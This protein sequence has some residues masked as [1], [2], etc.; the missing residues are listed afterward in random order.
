MLEKKDDLV[1][2]DFNML[3]TEKIYYIN[4]S[5]W[6]PSGFQLKKKHRVLF[7]CHKVQV[8]LLF[9]VFFEFH[10][11]KHVYVAVLYENRTMNIQLEDRKIMRVVMSAL[12]QAI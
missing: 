7:E 10:I 2:F 3:Q 5:K 11:I 6:L 4:C 8:L 9:D 12:K 1:L